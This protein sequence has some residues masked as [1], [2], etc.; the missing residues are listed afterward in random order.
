M[1]LNT[2]WVVLEYGLGF[3]LGVL[4]LPL[5]SQGLLSSLA[6]ILLKAPSLKSV[7]AVAFTGVPVFPSKH[8]YYLVSYAVLLLIL[9]HL[10]LNLYW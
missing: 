6:V 2:S 1:A 3:P 8:R 4:F 5:G 10:P 9:T 7:K